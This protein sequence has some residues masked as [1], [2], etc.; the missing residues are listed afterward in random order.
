[1]AETDVLGISNPFVTPPPF[2]RPIPIPRSTEPTEKC[3]FD[4]SISDSSS[5]VDRLESKEFLVTSEDIKLTSAVR[6]LVIRSQLP[7][8]VILPDIRGNQAIEIRITTISEFGESCGHTI[9]PDDPSQTIQDQDQYT[10]NGR[11]VIVSHKQKWY[12]F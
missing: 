1:M 4:I 12:V 10:I 3:M 8:R 7:R 5:R 11:A 9:A 2:T 6:Y